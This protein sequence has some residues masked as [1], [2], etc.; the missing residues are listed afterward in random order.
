[1]HDMLGFG[2]ERSFFKVFGNARQVME[3][4]FRDYVRE[5]KEGTFPTEEMGHK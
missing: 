4:A 5:V 1:M 3:Q 2:P